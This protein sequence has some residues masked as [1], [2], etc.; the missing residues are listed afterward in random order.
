MPGPGQY[1]PHK[2]PVVQEKFT[3]TEAGKPKKFESRVSGTC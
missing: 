3:I 2:E 1:N